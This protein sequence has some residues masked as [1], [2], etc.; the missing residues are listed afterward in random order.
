M[1]LMEAIRARHS[2]RSYTDRPLEGEALAELRQC[3]DE[4]N[5]ESGLHIQLCLNEPE[6]FGGMLARYGKFTGVRHYVA[7]VGKKG[8]GQEDAC[9]YY[10]EKVALRA[11]Q[12]GLNICWVAG[13]YSKGKSKAVTAP[14]EKLFLV[15]SIGYGATQGTAH[16]N[17]PIDKLCQVEGEMP[18]W[19]QKGMEA[20]Q[21]A[22]TAMNQ[23]KFLFSLHG[24]RVAAAPGTGMYTRIDLGIAKYHFAVAAGDADWAWEA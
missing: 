24:N 21:L 22:P 3:I 12:L 7:L 20:A 4:C 6:V 18:P 1:D 14:G 23:Q 15:I 10:G 9:G 5:R 16:K 13:T 8:P 11:Q 17:K 19:F 2:V